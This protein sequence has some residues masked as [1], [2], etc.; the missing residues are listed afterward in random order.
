MLNTFADIRRRLGMNILLTG[1]PDITGRLTTLL[2][3]PNQV[4]PLLADRDL[5]RRGSSSRPSTP[6]FAWP[7][8]LPSSPWMPVCPSIP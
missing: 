8:V 3:E 5:S 4:V 2:R 1:E 6:G 7:Q